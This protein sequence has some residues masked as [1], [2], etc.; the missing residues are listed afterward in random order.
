M[1]RSRREV[2]SLLVGGGA[3][4][5][6]GRATPLG[7]PPEYVGFD[8]CG[9]ALGRSCADAGIP[10]PSPVT[11]PELNGDVTIDGVERDRAAAD[12]GPEGVVVVGRA[13][14]IGDPDCRTVSLETDA[15]ENALEAS[16][17]SGVESNGNGC[18]ESSA[19]VCYRLTVET[20]AMSS[21]PERLVLTHVSGREELLRG[22]IDLGRHRTD[23]TPAT[24]RIS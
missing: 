2:L 18:A 14:G 11:G 1:P 10:S 9:P 13:Y 22:S 15:R 6:I 8:T 7:G 4:G 3:G 16:V 12:L 5:C 17:R 23:D 19:P 24:E 20:Q 21:P